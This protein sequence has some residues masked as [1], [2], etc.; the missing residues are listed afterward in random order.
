ML[1]RVEHGQMVRIW[2]LYESSAVFDISARHNNLQRDIPMCNSTG[3]EIRYLTH[4][5]T[6]AAATDNS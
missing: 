6:T 3:D 2:A 4:P 1:R 5:A